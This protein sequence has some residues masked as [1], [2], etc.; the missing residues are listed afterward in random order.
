MARACVTLVTACTHACVQLT[1]ACAWHVYGTHSG[2]ALLT[3]FTLVLRRATL[4]FE[5]GGDPKWAYATG[6]WAERRQPPTA[7]RD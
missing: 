6:A 2:C 1:H 4:G 3:L 5:L 7:A